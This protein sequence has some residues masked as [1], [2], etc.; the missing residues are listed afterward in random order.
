MPESRTAQHLPTAPRAEVF[1]VSE[2]VADLLAGRIRIPEFQRGWK[3]KR[4][5][6][7]NLLD[8]IYRGYPIGSLLFWQRPQPAERLVIGPREILAP[9]RGDARAVI[10]GQQRLTT[11]LGTLA[12]PEPPQDPCGDF[13]VFFD[14]VQGRFLHR[15]RGNETFPDSWVPVSRLL[16]AAKLQD[17]LFKRPYFQENKELRR[18]VLEAGAR[19]REARIPAYIVEGE[20]ESVPREIYRRTNRGGSPMEENDVFNSIVG[21]SSKPGKI[22]ELGNEAIALGMGGELGQ[23]KLLQCVMAVAGLDVTRRLN[24]QH[25][26]NGLHEA[27]EATAPALRSALVFLESEA[28]IP[29][30]R[31]LPYP[32]PL[33]VL[34]RFFHFF[35]E[36]SGRSRL[37]LVRWLWR[38]MMTAAHEHNER[39]G[40]RASVQAVRALEEEP[41]VQ[42]LLALVPR[43]QPAESW[44]TQ[45]RFDGRSAASRIAGLWLASRG[46]RHVEKGLPIDIK[47]LLDDA[48]AEAFRPLPRL[49]A[50]LSKLSSSAAGR[51]LHPKGLRLQSLIKLARRSDPESLTILSS[52]GFDGETLEHLAAG[53]WPESIK[54]RQ[55]SFT[56]GMMALAGRLAGWGHLDRPS[57][58]FLLSV[59]GNRG[60][61]A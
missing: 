19:L 17:Y 30:L 32:L 34:T 44:W 57:I 39:A 52:H 21:R 38:G 26:L 8:S 36:P 16:D 12:H 55:A 43:Q 4:P 24:D 37:L 33:I 27:L 49:T 47:R 13:V 60:F 61:A 42:R 15:S 51:I 58:A 41:S 40:L 9:E 54:L 56:Q 20:D 7:L 22:E 23:H 5:Q 50:D 2:L 1:S 45:A 18:K 25:D 59:G 53:R 48:G 10:D 6:I 28:K 31:L 29:H 35:P 3:W 14:S 46:P 11:L